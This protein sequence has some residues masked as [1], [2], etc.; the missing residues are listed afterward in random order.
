MFTTTALPLSAPKSQRISTVLAFALLPLSGFATDIYIPSLPSMGADLHISSIQVQ[1][2]LTLFL[3]SYGIS[4]LFL[5]SMLDAYGRYRFS[6]S[7][8]VVFILASVVIAITHNIYVI[9]A[10]RIIHGITVAM[11]V[12]AKRA[13]FVDV[14]EGERLK[15]YLSMFTIIWSAGPIVAPFLGG[16]FQKTFGWQSNFYFLAALALV[17]A[18]LEVIYSGETIRH[19]TQFHLKKIANIYVE[20]IKASTFSLGILMLSFAY[21]MVIMYNMT[22]PFIIE[23]HFLAT[24]VVAGYCSLILGLAWMA[25]GFIG[26]ALIN[27]P[28]F[29]KLFVNILLQ[30]LMV[31]L[32][33][34]SIKFVSNIYA[35]VFFAFLIH[36]GAGFTYNNYFTY[37]LGRFPKNAAM[38]GGFTGGMVYVILSLLT[39]VVVAVIHAKDEQNLSYSYLVFILLSVIVMLI[40][41]KIN[42]KPAAAEQL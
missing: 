9:Y 18:V 3:V 4:Q 29:G 31:V 5:G 26:K 19:R 37:C 17:I 20:M 11:I 34:I 28:F 35:M 42:R 12:V 30:L 16:Y 33:I 2:T 39:Y 36:V 6:L 23:H 13:Y 41:F 27:R 25:G 24:P 14:Y 38:S 1:L 15:H 21:S 22:G 8:L 7:A 32:M 40:L 10:M